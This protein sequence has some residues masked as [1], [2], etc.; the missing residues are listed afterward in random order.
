[1]KNHKDPKIVMQHKELEDNLDSK[2]DSI[3][4]MLDKD[5]NGVVNKVEFSWLSVNPHTE[6]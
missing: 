2:I 4:E 1:M 3:F 6:F 5:S